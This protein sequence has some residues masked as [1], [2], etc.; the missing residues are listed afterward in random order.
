M[1][2][3]LSIVI[4]EE[5]THLAIFAK[6]IFIYCPINNNIFTTSIPSYSITTCEAAY[7]KRRTSYYIYFGFI[8][9]IEWHVGFAIFVSPY[10]TITYALPKSKL[11]CF[12]FS[13]KF[14]GY[15][16]PFIISILSIRLIE[17]YTVALSRSVR[18]KTSFA[19]YL[20]V[21]L[22]SHIK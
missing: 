3:G 9:I 11:S 19:K 18:R 2:I 10:F 12:I 4:R 20:E 22:V 1:P 21:S 7:L 6:N 17:L 16:F 8:Y 13:S 5:N 15:F 14:E